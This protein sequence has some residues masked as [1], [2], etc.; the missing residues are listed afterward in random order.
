MAKA[1]LTNLNPP[2]FVI[3]DDVRTEV[4]GKPFLIGVYPG[5]TILLA[6]FPGVAVFRVWAVLVP[7]VEGEL[8]GTFKVVRI[9]DE[10]TAF[11]STANFTVKNVGHTMPTRYFCRCNVATPSILE[12]RVRI[13]DGDWLNLG[14]IRVTSKAELDKK[15]LM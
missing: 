12:A 8:N 2:Q 9:E 1:A 4:G 10:S 14:R 15:P 7:W 11:E 5:N 3:C 13:G 6:S